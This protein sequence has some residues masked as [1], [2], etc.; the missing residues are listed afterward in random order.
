[1]AP[2]LYMHATRTINRGYD[3]PTRAA[4]LWSPHTQSTGVQYQDHDA[5]L[6]K[7]PEGHI[8]VV[9]VLEGQRELSCTQGVGGMRVLVP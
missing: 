2:C 9:E 6:P 5:Y 7:A 3:Q 8:V 1:M 4:G